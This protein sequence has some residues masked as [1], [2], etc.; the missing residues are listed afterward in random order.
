MSNDESDHVPAFDELDALTR[1]L[2][3]LFCMFADKRENELPPLLA[4]NSECLGSED[5]VDLD[6]RGRLRPP[7]TARP[8]PRKPRRQLI[9]TERREDIRADRAA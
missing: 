1:S 5:G 7:S 8:E 4:N 9:A 3:H 6:T 2:N